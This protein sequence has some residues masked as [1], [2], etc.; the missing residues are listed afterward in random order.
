MFEIKDKVFVVTGG[1]TGIGAGV[2]RTLV[3]KGAK[4]VGILDTR[5]IDGVMLEEEI[6]SVHGLDK[7]KF[8]KCDV[9]S[10]DINASFETI[11][12]LFG[13]IDVVVNNAGMMRDSKNFYLREISLNLTAVVATSFKAYGLMRKDKE[14]GA[15]GTIVNISS[16]SGLMLCPY[17]PVYSATKGAVLQ[18]GT[19]LGANENFSRTGV[20]VITICYGLT[21]TKMLKQKNIAFDEDV[22]QKL[23]EEF[24]TLP[25]QTVEEA[26]A[27]FVTAFEKGASGSSW[28][29]SSKN[30][31]KEITNNVK[32]YYTILSEGIAK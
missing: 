14:G 5:K 15:G 27:G 1:A 30:P 4:H 29:V 6:K 22:E 28:L 16:I 7:V 2:V 20:R 11:Q 24:G 31:A 18:F 8:L 26:V 13:Y 9:S 25:M 10:G 21:S 12:K 23:L 3:E 17:V 32:K 19:C